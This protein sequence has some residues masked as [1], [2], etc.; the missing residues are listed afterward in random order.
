[1][2]RLQTYA[3][4]LAGLAA[5]DRKRQLVLPSGS[6]FS[7]ND[8]LGLSHS[9]FLRDAARA[10][11]DMGIPHGAGGSRLLGGNHG[12]HEELEAF[13]AGHYGS[14]AALF[15]GSGFAANNALFATLPQSGDLVL[16]DALI[17]ASVH[18]GMK[19]GRASHR[20]FRHGDCT[21]LEQKIGDWRHAGGKGTPWIAVESLYSMDG[22]LAPLADLAAVAD[23]HE[24]ML[25]IDEAHAV[26]V[27]G[28]QGKGLSGELGQ[29]ENVLTLRTCGKALGV[30]GG[31]VTMAGV[32]RDFFINRARAFIFSTAPSP[33]TAHLVRQSIG[34]VANNARL[35][36]SLTALVDET[37]SLLSGLCPTRHDGTQI[38]P[39]IVGDDAR[40]LAIADRLQQQGFDVRAIRPPTVP[41]G[42]ARL[43]I[44]L[45]L[46]VGIDEIRALAS[47]VKEAMQMAETA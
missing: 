38:F 28:D 33:L 39:V 2:D 47:A 43:R 3:D 19:L 24:A 18:D 22:D 25:V 12:E 14:E 37:Q 36:E 23:R 42:T 7:S 21:D 26:G 9:N 45:T 29:R 30:E 4:Q 41:E 1:M 15:F 17:H 31:L 44:S 20:A 40:A 34:H 13:A 6:D 46:N 32:L 10:A 8:Y 35:R 5:S 16:Y 27:F 11:L